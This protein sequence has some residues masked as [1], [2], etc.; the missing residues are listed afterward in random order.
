MNSSQPN[1][2]TITPD[3]GFVA[4]MGGTLPPSATEVKA[5]LSLP[6][7]DQH[8]HISCYRCLERDGDNSCENEAP[9]ESQQAQHTT[10]VFGHHR[11]VSGTAN[12]AEADEIEMRVFGSR[13]AVVRFK[14]GHGHEGDR[15]TTEQANVK[16]NNNDNNDILSEV[17]NY[18]E[19]LNWNSIRK[20]V[21]RRHS[22]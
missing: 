14:A 18:I 12:V 7:S 8:R 15:Q 21:Q 16:N 20:P 13:N 10:R 22:I 9:T 6:R 19:K 5:V 3:C 2:E 1:H 11:F 4:L 17:E